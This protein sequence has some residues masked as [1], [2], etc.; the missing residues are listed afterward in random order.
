[1]PLI[2][3]WEEAA[4]EGREEGNSAKPYACCLRGLLERQHR[5]E[6]RGCRRKEENRKRG[7]SG[8]KEAA[9]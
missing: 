5:G 1:M 6:A 2:E 4:G 8:R 9:S 3:G 7:G